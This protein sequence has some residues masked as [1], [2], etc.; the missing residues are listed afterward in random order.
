MFG[1]VLGVI[2]FLLK[3]LCIEELLFSGWF[4]VFAPEWFNFELS[5]NGKIHSR[6][7]NVFIYHL[8]SS[9]NRCTFL[10]LDG[11]ARWCIAMNVVGQG[12]GGNSVVLGKRAAA[13]WQSIIDS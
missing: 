6:R 13:I 2:N 7:L 9:S 1:E 4:A 11:I 5:F 8:A 10:L 3:S 12:D